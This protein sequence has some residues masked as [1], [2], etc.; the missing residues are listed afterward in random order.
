MK[1]I[2]LFEGLHFEKN[3]YRRERLKTKIMIGTVLLT[4]LGSISVIGYYEIGAKLLDDETR[5]IVLDMA[6]YDE[7]TAMKD[8]INHMEI[9]ISAYRLLEQTGRSY[10]D[11]EVL[12]MLANHFPAGVSADNMSFDASGNISITGSANAI[13]EVAYLISRLKQD[14]RVKTVFVG[15]VTANNIATET[16]NTASSDADLAHKNIVFALSITL[17]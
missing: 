2:N 1:D 4:L 14:E 5:Q 17:R 15:N 6:T 10:L 16:T 9:R 7:I 12:A 13:D 11:T 8:K 3:E